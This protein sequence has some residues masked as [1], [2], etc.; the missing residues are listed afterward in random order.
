MDSIP[1]PLKA[2]V[3]EALQAWLLSRPRPRP[4]ALKL[5]RRGKLIAG[6]YECATFNP[7]SSARCQAASV[8][9]PGALLSSGVHRNLC[10]CGGI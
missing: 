5:A 8:L 10:G 1:S 7:K 2:T 3:S 4:G 6:V 9:N